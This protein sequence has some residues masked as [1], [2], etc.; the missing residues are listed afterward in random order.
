MAA[1]TS[2]IP[3]PSPLRMTGGV[4]NLATEWKRFRG[5]WTNY[6]T[7]AKIDDE[8]DGRKAAI[9]LA[10]IGADAYELYET[11]ELDDDHRTDLTR[12][13]AAFETHCVGEV[14]VVYERYVFYKRKQDNGEAFESFLAELRKLVKTCDF[15]A[16]EDSTVRDRIVMG[17]RDD[18]TRRK[19]LQTRKLDLKSAIDICRASESAMNQ[20]RAMTKADD[21]V[22]AV[23]RDAPRRDG[24]DGRDGRDRRDRRDVRGRSSSR[25]PNNRSGRQR[26]STPHHRCQ[27]CGRQHDTGKSSCPAYGKTCNAC[28]RKNHFA[29]VCK[30]KTK[31]TVYQLE[32][33]ADQDTEILA[34]DSHPTSRCYSRLNVAGRSVRFM[35]D[36][37]S[38]VNLLPA[39][40]VSQ[41]GPAARNVRRPEANLRMFDGTL[42]QTDGMVILPVSHP[43]TGQSEQLTFYIATKHKQPLI[44]IEACLMFD[45]MNINYDNICAV[46]A[47]A[48]AAVATPLT[49]ADVKRDYA[50]VFEGYGRL[51]GKVSLEVDPS[52]QPV[53]MP[54]RKLPIP[55]RD[56]VAKELQ[57][58]EASGII[59]RVTEPT[60]WIS[61]LLVTAKAS[62]D[63]RVCIDPTPL[64]RALLRDHHYMPGIDDILPNLT[65]A[66]VFSTCD[67][68]SAF[69][70]LE[71]DDKTSLLTTFETPFGKYKW[72]RLP[73]GVSPAP[74]LFQRRIQEVLADLKGVACIADDILIVGCGASLQEA[75]KDHD[76]NVRQLL[77]RCREKNLKLNVSKF[78]LNRKEVPFMGHI[79]T[80]TGLRVSDKKVDAIRRM[81]DPTDRQ[82]VLRLLGMAT[83]LARYTP[84]FSEITAPL[85]A[86]LKRD[87]EFRWDSTVHGE[88]VTK[89]KDA[90]SNA[91]VLRYYDVNKPVTVQCDSSQSGLG[92]AILQEGHPVEFAS[93]A[94]T[95]TEQ[96]W[97]QIEKEQL[98]VCFALDRF[99][100]YVYGRRV[101]VETDHRPLVAIKQKSLATAPKRLQRMLLKIQKYDIDLVYRRGTEVVVADT[102]SRAYLPDPATATSFT[103]ELAAI[104]AEQDAETRTI[105]SPATLQL[106]RDAAADDYVYK[107]LK[108]QIASGW[109]TD[110][111]AVPDELRQY[112]TFADELVI[113]QEFVYKG[114]RL[115]IP[116]G[117]RPW[118]LE[119]IHSGHTGIN[120]CLRR[121]RE[122]VFWP[123]MTAELKQ[124]VAKCHI[125]QTHQAASA[126]EPLSPHEAPHRPWEK[127][128]VDIFTFRSQSYLLT[129]CYF[130]N[131]FEVDRLPT[132]RVKD[133]IYALKGQFARHGSPSVVMSD[134][135]PFLAREFQDFAKSWDFVH[136]TSSPRYPQSNGKV[137]RAIQVVKSLLQKAV[138]DSR[139]P[140]LALL[141]FRNTPSESLQ[142]SPVQIIFGRR[143]RSL[144]PIHS[145]LL[146]TQS[147]QQTR[148]RLMDSK[149][150]QTIYYNRK[151][152]SPRPPLE[153]GQTVR[154]KPTS[155]DDW[156]KGEIVDKL[157][158]RSYRVRTPDGSTRRRTS[159]HVRISAEPPIVMDYS[160]LAPT[161][162]CKMPSPPP[163]AAGTQKQ[164]SPALSTPPTPATSATSSTNA[165][166]EPASTTTK[167]RC[168]RTIIK[169]ARYR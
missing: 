103:N 68:K 167:T 12:I 6:S 105:A 165:M 4:G 52:V 110:T 41:L 22:H 80:D 19:L 32:D 3:V 100:T 162:E 15:G 31:P 115:V 81:P 45:L 27:Y 49:M 168:G 78:C 94:L 91:P 157:P 18:T 121:A 88:A 141:E 154:F 106:I 112:Y 134:C 83:Y 76:D 1:A 64:N 2:Q 136:Q 46:D 54:L 123:G 63:L 38:S 130:S 58:L 61:S 127:V 51:E 7:A 137:E 10:C 97:S 166:T 25:K 34:L 74:E 117:A 163:A 96:T 14:N 104:D 148:H 116:V 85:R 59:A 56:R 28:N 82:A 72:L 125:C 24:R 55:I 30:S 17:I 111:N 11:F 138:D 66:K 143:T 33:D 119:R 131:Y 84:G 13:M 44:G 73:Y 40:L 151:A 37:G 8:T 133:V 90:L 26:S 120:S 142:L 159:R 114:Q 155:D 109:P 75:Q 9:F 161:I 139:D 60:P 93:R 99:H 107:A 122:L 135:S 129:V 23:T 5:Q 144:I 124:V 92:A 87:N 70:H 152:T 39:S 21:D 169:P 156:R 16:V 132:K 89:I 42:L 153:I 149:A 150:K 36:S 102:L 140:F 53:R 20:L 98:A 95:P 65:Q 86:L 147:S 113:C 67:C 126:R 43:T 146:Q 108:Q 118:I 101:R 35:M 57:H 48:A 29:S 50:D 47:A 160:E 128:G 158:F 164:S 145:T 77:T 69:W 71:L 79:L 62:G